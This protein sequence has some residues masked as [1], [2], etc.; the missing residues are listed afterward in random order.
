[1]FSYCGNNPINRSDP[2]GH[3]WKSVWNTIKTA[4]TTA[5]KAVSKAYMKYVANPVVNLAKKLSSKVISGTKSYSVTGSAAAGVGATGSV[6]FAYDG[7]G[8][9]GL[10]YSGGGGGGMPSASLSLTASVTNAPT[11]D[12]LQGWSTQMGGSVSIGPAS[13]GVEGTF[14]NS[15]IDS[16]SYSGVVFSGGFGVKAIPVE[17]HVEAVYSENIWQINV[18]DKF[19]DAYNAVMEW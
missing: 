2:S 1:M 8:N 15:D 19:E 16:K 5:A 6:G 10:F 17:L 11:I 3:S 18:F 9:V 4:V 14:F 12:Y 13:A 7:A